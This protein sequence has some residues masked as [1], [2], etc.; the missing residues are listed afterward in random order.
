MDRFSQHDY[1]RPSP[2]QIE[3]FIAHYFEF[4]PR[5]N[6]RELVIC[7]PFDGDVDYHFNVSKVKGVCH[8][9]HG[10][11]GWAGP[12]S[13]RS[14]KR[15]TSFVRFVQL[16]LRCSYRDAIRVICDLS[17]D[18]VPSLRGHRGT[19][20]RPGASEAQEKPLV[21]LPGLSERLV[22]SS[23]PT[24]A[25]TILRWLS[26]RGVDRTAVERYDIHHAGMDVVWP[27]YELGALV[28]WQTR[29]MLNKRFAFPDEVLYGVGKSQFLY[30]FDHIEP[31]DDL[32]IAESIFCCHTLVHQ[33]LATG[34]ADMTPQQAQKVQ[35]LRPTCVVLTP[36][37]DAAGLRS[38]VHNAELLAAR[39]LP[40]YYSIPPYLNYDLDGLKLV[41]KDW[42]EI[43][44]YVTGFASHAVWNL[45]A[46]G[47]TLYTAAARWRLLEQA[48][49]LDS[50]RTKALD[51]SVVSRD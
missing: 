33:C 42:N 15:N 44:Q 24:A 3:A 6:G 48:R 51:L 50:K 29:N 30:N 5:K 38:I 22:G 26:T 36:D 39:G 14:G 28:Y 8:D 37:N 18:A 19:A 7:N 25:R 35:L 43:G 49:Q 20:G 2:E 10:D 32:Y 12:P 34:G 13:P 9:W 1:F 23:Q 46:T 45:M 27:Y 11:D 16:F 41:S 47:V 31:V 40:V 21:A 4:K 17:G